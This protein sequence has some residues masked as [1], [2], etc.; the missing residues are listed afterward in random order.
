MNIFEIERGGV[1]STMKN[2]LYLIV[3]GLKQGGGVTV[4]KSRAPSCG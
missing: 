3:G 4:V 1:V 2:V